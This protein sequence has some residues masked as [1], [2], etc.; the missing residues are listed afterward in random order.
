[1]AFLSSVFQSVK[2]TII[3]PVQTTRRHELDNGY[4]P[5]LLNNTRRQRMGK[6]H[7]I[8]LW[9][10][11]LMTLMFSMFYLSGGTVKLVHLSTAAKCHWAV[12]YPAHESNFTNITHINTDE[13][14][15]ARVML[16]SDLMERLDY[17]MLPNSKI[18]HQSWGARHLPERFASWS[19]QWRKLHGSDWTY[20]NPLHHL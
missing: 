17:D 7:R 20:V 4:S 10:L 19:E 18:L 12:R 14:Q 6:G 13:S 1:M 3:D 9:I 5:G 11:I 2:P 15:W 16:P 8:T